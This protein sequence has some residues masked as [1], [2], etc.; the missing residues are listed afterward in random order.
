VK[1]DDFKK[2]GK[3]FFK[4][5]RES[6]QAT[7]SKGFQVKSVTLTPE[8]GVKASDKPFLVAITGAIDE[9]GDVGKYLP[10]ALGMRSVPVAYSA[11][12]VVGFEL[13]PSPAL[14][15]ILGPAFFIAAAFIGFIGFGAWYAGRAARRG[16][17]R[18]LVSYYTGSYLLNC[19]FR[20]TQVFPGDDAIEALRLIDAGA[21]DVRR[22]IEKTF[23][24]RSF[25]DALFLWQTMWIMAA[26]AR[27]G[28]KGSFEAGAKALED[29]LLR[30]LSEKFDF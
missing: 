27:P 17:T 1:I 7:V 28:E 16:D 26:G 29:F 3:D 21:E 19:G 8:V 4:T 18:G 11:S 10:A 20:A 12:I 5:L 6:L 14:L 9:K 24:G 22:D 30:R 25:K 23:P 15:R 13:G 2:P